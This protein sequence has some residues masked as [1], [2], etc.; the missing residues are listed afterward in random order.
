[1][2]KPKNEAPRPSKKPMSRA[3]I[4]GMVATAALVFIFVFTAIFVWLA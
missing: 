2:N 3:R 4:S 1:M